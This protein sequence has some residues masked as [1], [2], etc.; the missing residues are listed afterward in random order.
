MAMMLL[1]IASD[2]HKF[3]KTEQQGLIIAMVYAFIFDALFLL[4][5]F[6]R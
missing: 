3:S 2:D 5:L 6:M 1:L 4:A